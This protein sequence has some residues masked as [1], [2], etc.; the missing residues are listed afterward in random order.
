M[1]ERPSEGLVGRRLE[2]RFLAEAAA[3]RGLGGC[4]GPRSPGSE[5]G[6]AAA[7]EEDGAV[8]GLAGPWKNPGVKMR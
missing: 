6:G 3:R 5:K 8:A 4:P 1:D 2:V 7:T